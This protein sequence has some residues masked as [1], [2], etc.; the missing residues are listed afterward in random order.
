MPM[1]TARMLLGL[2]LVCVP[3]HGQTRTVPDWTLEELMRIRIAPVFGASKRLQPVTEA[4]ASVTIV[5]RE[6]I[7]R[8]GYRTLAEVLRGARGFFVT[9]DRNY[10]YLGARGFARPGDFGTRILLLVD[11][12]RMNDNIYEQA[13]VG[14]EF[15][16]DAA[17]FERVE[18]VRGPASALYG[19][20]AFFAIVNVIMRK[21]TDLKGFNASADIGSF[22]S[23]NATLAFGRTLAGGL[24]VVLSA[25]TSHT[26]GAASLYF[27]EFDSPE[28]NYGRAQH[29]DDEH[30]TQLFGRANFGRLTLTG[31]YGTRAKGVPTASYGSVFND[32]RLRTIDRRGFVDVEYGRTAKDT[33][34][35]L[36][37]YVD[38]YRY[39]G[40]YPIAGASAEPYRDYAIGTWF[41]GEARIARDIRWKQAITVG[42]EFRSSPRQAQGG[43]DGTAEGSFGVD[44]AASAAALYVQDDIQVFSKVRVSL[45]ARY[46]S[47]G[48]FSHL[49]PRAAL[50][51]APSTNQ[52]IKYL[53]ATAFRAPNAFELDYYSE[54]IRND[55]LRP[56]TIGS[57]ELVWERYTGSWLR[58]SASLYRNKVSRL[59]NLEHDPAG[60]LELI[61]T[62]RGEVR[63]AGAEFEAEWR[64]KRVEGVA[65]YTVQRT[66]DRDSGE[67]LTNSPA[68]IGKLRFSAPGPLRGSTLAFE[69]QY[70]GPRKT[71]AGGLT[72]AAKTA[73]V[74]II[75][76]VGAHIEAV[77]AVRNLFNV[78]Y[79]DPGSAEHRQDILQQDGRT[80]SIGL[81]WQFRHK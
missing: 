11:G 31:A 45:G 2:L 75:A 10:S 16:V 71:L 80:F 15:G 51:V 47:Y 74:T 34:V 29:L 50:I 55:T 19:T 67:E 61:W 28:T 23:R 59:L 32:P 1:R 3:A 79:G 5:T 7:A 46:D 58:T 72:R 66:R 49:T 41:G 21:G 25:T 13:A 26:N 42:S 18:I 43:T 30:A 39:E 38:R 37:G 60:P 36:R 53:Y 17:M 6:E 68:H 35:V 77:G 76:P 8:Y 65:S 62:N 40:T 56:E 52:S 22:G 24:D 73:N 64:Y 70:V 20:S 4:P 54:G 12:H 63:S 78:A 48:E 81:R 27:P 44:R 9:S 57:N 14:R 33:Q 69:T